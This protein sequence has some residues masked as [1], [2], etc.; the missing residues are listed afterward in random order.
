M[1]VLTA[2]QVKQYEAAFDCVWSEM[3]SAIDR[4]EAQ[5]VNADA[6][7]FLAMLFVSSMGVAQQRDPREMRRL[8]ADCIQGAVDATGNAA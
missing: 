5:G 7:F 8:F 1:A 4:C 2:T 6:A 3:R